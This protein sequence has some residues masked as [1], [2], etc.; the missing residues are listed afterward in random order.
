[1]SVNSRIFTFGVVS[2]LLWSLPFCF[3][4]G[5]D[6]ARNTVGYLICGIFSGVLVSFALK[7][8]VAKFG[9]LGTLIAGLVSLPLGAFI[10]SFLYALVEIIFEGTTGNP[11]IA[12]ICC[13]AISVAS[14][15]A[16]YLFPL[17]IL[18]T[19]ALRFVVL[20]GKKRGNAA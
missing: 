15:F 9:W 13:A 19:F 8:P 20:F 12:G 6:S 14:M 18:T 1:M 7:V 4:D 3:F 17:A 2:G 5:F 11:L 10:F 16:F